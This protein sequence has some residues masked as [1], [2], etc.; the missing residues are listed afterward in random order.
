[1]TAA[2]LTLV[3][4]AQP[5]KLLR[6]T[7]ILAKDAERSGNIILAENYRQHGEHYQRIIN[8][9][10]DDAPVSNDKAPVQKAKKENIDDDLGLPASITGVQAKQEELT[11]V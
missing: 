3:S 5:F 1:M 4:A 7:E 10:E 2:A 11:S 9:F 6:N 8:S